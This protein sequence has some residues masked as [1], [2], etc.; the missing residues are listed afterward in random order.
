MNVFAKLN[1]DIKCHRKNVRKS[2]Q[3]N[4]SIV[5]KYTYIATY[6]WHFKKIEVHNYSLTHKKMLTISNQMNQYTGMVFF[7]LLG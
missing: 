5:N 7:E 4:M 1:Q 3:K 6:Q 2:K